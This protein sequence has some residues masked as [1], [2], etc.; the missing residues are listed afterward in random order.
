M[1]DKK[2][3]TADLERVEAFLEDEAERRDCSGLTGYIKEASGALA[4]FRRARTACLD[5]R[6]AGTARL[7]AAAL[8]A[9]CGQV[10][11]FTP[12]QREQAHND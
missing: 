2:K 5:E 6:R 12:G 7:F 9:D 11:R 4:A 1:Y 3:L 8:P 10:E